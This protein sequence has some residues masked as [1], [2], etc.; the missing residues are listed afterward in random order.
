MTHRFASAVSAHPVTHAAVGEVLGEVLEQ[1]GTTPDLAVV[2]FTDAHVPH[3]EQIAST[4]HSV[5]APTVL[6]GTSAVGVLGCGEGIESEPGLTL[7]TGRFDDAFSPVEALDLRVTRSNHAVS[8]SGV[9]DE[10]LAAAD[11]L[12]LLTDP[13]TFPLASMLDHLSQHH[14]HL[15]VL[16]GIASAG[17]SSGHNRLIVG[18][19]S[20]DSGAVGVLLPPGVLTAT[21]VSQGCRPIGQPW[22]VT[23]SH[24]NVIEQLGGRP[25]LERLRDIVSSASAED[26]ALAMAGL[27]C[28]L[29]AD[30]RQLDPDRGDFLVRGVLGIDDDRGTVSVGADVAVGTVMQFHVRDAATA[31][32]DLAVRLRDAI[33][34]DLTRQ[35]GALVFTCNGR[36]RAMFDTPHHDAA[37]VHRVVGHHATGLMCAGEIGPVAGRTHLHGFT[38]SVAVF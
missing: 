21:V 9:E 25:A 3:A 19:Q 6:V 15:R 10:R 29:L 34:V 28:G 36:G 35:H 31:G 17:Q 23:A 14:P 16:G 20:R 11:A 38:A 7:W 4:V 1:L 5:L 12:I 33:S 27:H 22:T 24:G 26:R 30:D 37:I 2:T 8:V 13:W 32:E 18:S